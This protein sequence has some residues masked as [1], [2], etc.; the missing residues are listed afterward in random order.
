MTANCQNSI[1]FNEARGN[2]PGINLSFP[3]EFWSKKDNN[4]LIVNC[5]S[6]KRVNNGDSLKADDCLNGTFVNA[7]NFTQPFINFTQ[8]WRI[9]DQSKDNI[10]PTQRFLPHQNHLTIYPSKRLY[11]NVEGCVNTL[12]GECVQFVANYGRSGTNNTAQSRYQCYYNKVCMLSVII[13]AIYLI[14][15]K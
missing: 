3:R 11:I 12:R 13:Y 8:F 5:A 6:V 7:S 9:Y 2:K 4:Y 15:Y 1:A 10:D 14:K